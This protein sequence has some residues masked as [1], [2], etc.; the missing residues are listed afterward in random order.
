M[1]VVYTSIAAVV[2]DRPR[3]LLFRKQLVSFFFLAVLAGL[4]FTD[5]EMFL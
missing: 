3:Y 2:T 5:I 1:A 4:Q